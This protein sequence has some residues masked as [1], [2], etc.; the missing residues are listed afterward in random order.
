MHSLTC[1]LVDLHFGFAAAYC[2]R[3]TDRT[4]R[5]ET[6]NQ[7]LET[8]GQFV[9]KYNN[10][11]PAHIID[12]NKNYISLDLKYHLYYNSFRMW[13]YWSSL[14]S[15][16]IG[17]LLTAVYSSGRCSVWVESNVRFVRLG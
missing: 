4:C 1:V 12:K 11:T 17:K 14:D 3:Q 7:L 8:V 5:G 15:G 10:L 13:A 6:I 16:A 2:H 9:T